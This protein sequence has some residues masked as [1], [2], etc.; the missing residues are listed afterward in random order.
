MSLIQALCES[1]L[2]ADNPINLTFLLVN[3]GSNLANA[4]NSVVQTG[5]KSSGW[6][7]K[8][9]H[10]SPMYSWN[11]IFPLDVSASKSGAVDPNLNVLCCPDMIVA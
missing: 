6:E 7:N 2:L 9:A 4:P 1:V 10:E 11:E 3:S 8:I 5:V